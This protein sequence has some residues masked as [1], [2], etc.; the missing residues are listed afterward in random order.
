M[1]T[2]TWCEKSSSLAEKLHLANIACDK[3]EENSQEALAN[4]GKAVA[5]EM[6]HTGKV[7]THH[8]IRAKLRSIRE[9]LYIAKAVKNTPKGGVTLSK[10]ALVEKFAQEHNISGSITTIANA[11]VKEIE[12]VVNHVAQLAKFDI[13][14]CNIEQLEEALEAK[15]ESE[16]Q[17]LEA[18]V[19]I[20][21]I[22]EAEN[23]A[24]DVLS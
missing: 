1:N 15:R 17:A 23:L 9:G 6:K 2:L 12:N 5:E 18:G 22:V 16:I 7:P 11:N 19:A 4:I 13:R 20:E 8:S 3:T 10:A 14:T 21:D 24:S